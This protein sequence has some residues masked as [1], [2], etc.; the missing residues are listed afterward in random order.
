MRRRRRR[1]RRRRAAAAVLEEQC[2][3]KQVAVWPHPA[4]GSREVEGVSREL[5]RVQG[6]GEHACIVRTPFNKEIKSR[7]KAQ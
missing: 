7:T 5:E 4:G 6:G 2:A 1:R 3:Q